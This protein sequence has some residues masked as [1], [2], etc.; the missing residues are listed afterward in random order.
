MTPSVRRRPERISLTPCRNTRRWTPRTPS[1][2]R[3]RTAKITPSPCLSG[4][5]CGAL[6]WRGP[7]LDDHELAAVEV[8]ARLVQQERRLQREDVL[9]VEVLVQ[10]VVV[11]GAVGQQQGRGPRLAGLAATRQHVVH[12]FRKA[13]VLAQTL[14]PT[15][16]DRR[17]RTVETLPESLHDVRQGVAEVLVLAA[18]EAVAGHDHPTAE[19]RV[20]EIEVGDPLAGLGLQDRAGQ[21]PAARVELGADAN[22]VE[23]HAATRAPSRARRACLRST[24]QR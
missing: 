17:Q 8:P 12:R 15:V 7:L 4:T 5:T 18:S 22:P 10:A 23:C 1:A 16:G 11:A 3:S 2:G 19:A 9:A 13:A 14:G 20:L 24:P 21:G 6:C